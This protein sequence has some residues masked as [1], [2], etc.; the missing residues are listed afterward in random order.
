M[1][2][3][4]TSSFHINRYGCAE[5]EYYE[6]FILIGDGRSYTWH[7]SHFTQYTLGGEKILNGMQVPS[8]VVMVSVR[9]TEK[10]GVESFRASP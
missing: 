6:S 4:R 3:L 8:V 7:P 9:D 2:I 5:I 10:E 1:K